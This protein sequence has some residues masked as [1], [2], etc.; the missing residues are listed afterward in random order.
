MPSPGRFSE[1]FTNA[2][3]DMGHYAAELNFLNGSLK[4][5]AG[6]EC[7]ATGLIQSPPSQF[8]LPRR[9]TCRT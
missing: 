3:H 2:H 1:V 8:P 7:H 5:I 9:Q 4:L 6:G